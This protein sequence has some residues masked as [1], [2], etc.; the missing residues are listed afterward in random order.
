MKYKLLLWGLLLALAQAQIL[1][2]LLLHRYIAG[3][4]G[5]APGSLICHPP[6]MLAFQALF[7]LSDGR[8]R[9]QMNG[10]W[11]GR[12]EGGISGEWPKVAGFRSLLVRPMD[13]PDSARSAVKTVSD[14]EMMDFEYPGT[15][16]FDINQRLEVFTSPLVESLVKKRHLSKHT[17]MISISAGAVEGYWESAFPRENTRFRRFHSQLDSEG[18]GRTVAIPTM[19]QVG[20][21][22]SYAKLE[23]GEM[24]LVPLAGNTNVK[25][26][27][28]LSSIYF[29]DGKPHRYIIPR[30][31]NLT[32]LLRLGKQQ[33]VELQLPKMQF[34]YA[35]ELVPHILNDLGLPDL[36]SDAASFGR[37]SNDSKLRLSSMMHTAAID[38]D[39][40][41]INVVKQS[42]HGKK[43]IVQ[44]LSK[45]NGVKFFADRPFFFAILDQQQVYFTGEFWD[46]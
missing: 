17:Q 18:R 33:L 40:S 21:H 46:P 23:D 16:L 36:H 45:D 26:M 11:R 3:R 12:P 37:L 39:E 9:E 15:S 42:H 19:H 35:V 13:I 10:K 44:E 6:L 38:L 27:I 43:G 20:L 24:L 5:E 32:E 31:N 4:H 8:T 2:E 30:H 29:R 41:G 28:L 34:S 14:L 25:F 1:N 22:Y 7:L